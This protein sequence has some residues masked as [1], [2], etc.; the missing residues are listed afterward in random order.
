[1]VGF[2]DQPIDSTQAWPPPQSPVAGLSIAQWKLARQQAAQW[3]DAQRKAAEWHAARR[4][5]IDWSPPS[6]HPVTDPQSTARRRR[7]GIAAVLAVA[8]IATSMTTV[9]VVLAAPTDTYSLEASAAR[10]RDTTTLTYE[11]EAVRLGGATTF[12]EVQTDLDQRLTSMTMNDDSDGSSEYVFDI[13]RNRVYVEADLYSDIGFDV[14]DAEWIRFDLDEMW[15]TEA[16]GL[17]DQ[18]G[19]NPL[20][21]MLLLETADTIDDLG[22]EEVHGERVKHFVITVDDDTDL[23]A[24]EH[25]GFV[26]DGEPDPRDRAAFDVYVNKSNQMVRLKY[27]LQMMGEYASVDVTM[28]GVDEAVDVHVPQRA[29]VIEWDDIDL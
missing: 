9:V 26:N 1:M 5:S 3:H 19:E 24:V 4:R 13:A 7:T 29:D 27:G 22:F 20:D 16:S 14:G 17:Y 25:S 15:A 2:M 21:A 6:P 8:G 23:R 11:F 10:A 28:T 12:G 18:V